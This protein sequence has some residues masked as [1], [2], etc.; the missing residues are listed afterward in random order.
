[1][2]HGAKTEE[3]VMDTTTV[4]LEHGFILTRVL[5][6]PR[7]VVFTAWTD[8]DR[9]QWFFSDLSAP[10]E[11]ITVDL[12]VGGSWKQ[13]MV[14]NEST[15]YLTGGVYR[16]I[17]PVE[18]LVFVWGAT[19]GWPEID[20][21]HLENS[22]VATIAFTEL[23]PKTEMVFRLDLPEHLSDAGVSEWLATGV[24]E[25]WGETLDRLVARI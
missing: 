11:P 21:D 23:G 4:T 16:E 7:D 9:L 24:R 19:D 25:G 18:K 8:P 10:D 14:V 2:R 1:V 22:P 12:R 13:K 17:V 5:A 20:P 6:A 3:I 15:S